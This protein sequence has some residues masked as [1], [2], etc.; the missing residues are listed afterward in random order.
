MDKIKAKK[1][2]RKI[3]HRRLR[4]KISGTNSRLRL[5]VFRSGRH[6]YAQL[7]DDEKR[8][9]L[10]SVSDLKIK[11]GKNFKKSDVARQ[12]GQIL[13]EKA[14]ELKIKEVVFDRGGYKFHGRIKQLAQGARAGGLEF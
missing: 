12:V 7:V 14:V 4:S 2:K 1:E 11:K 6:I 5:S 10:I 3:R 8:K 9:T 13:A